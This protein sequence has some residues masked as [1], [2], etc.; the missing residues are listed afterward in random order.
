M[1]QGAYPTQCRAPACGRAP[2][3]AVADRP[4][5]WAAAALNLPVLRGGAGI[6]HPGASVVYKRAVAVSH[7]VP[8]LL[9]TASL[10][11]LVALG[12]CASRQAAPAGLTNDPMAGVSGQQL[13]DAGMQLA[14][15]GD[16]VRAEQYLVAS[17]QRGAP[18]GQVMPQLVS[19]CVQASRYRAAVSYATPY[20]DAHPR[21][22][23]LRYLVGTILAGLDEHQAARQQIE[24]VLTDNDRHAEAHYLLATLLRERFNDPTGADAH[25]RR[26]VEIEPAGAHVEEARAGMLRQVQK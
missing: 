17:M 26:Y 1:S 3:P 20:L 23:R 22:W 18:D 9:A 7:P 25:Y 12:G 13:F 19:V 16:L 15:S 11:A 14:R 10:A 4:V 24:R 6:C 5:R 2:S 8:P 21:D